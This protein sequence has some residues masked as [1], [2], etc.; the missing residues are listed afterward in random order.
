MKSVS[1][2]MDV[3]CVRGVWGDVGMRASRPHASGAHFPQVSEAG[4]K[5]ALQAR[6]IELTADTEDISI[7]Q[8]PSK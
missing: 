5:N 3:G 4:L 1:T 6:E 8:E 7:K 2:L